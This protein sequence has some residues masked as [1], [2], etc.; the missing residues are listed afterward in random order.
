MIEKGP[1]RGVE[2]NADMYTPEGATG[3]DPACRHGCRRRYQAA[4]TRPRTADPQKTRTHQRRRMTGELYLAAALR[5]GAPVESVRG[6]QALTGKTLAEMRH[7]RRSQDD[8]N[9]LVIEIARAWGR[10]TA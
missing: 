5:N 2:I 9:D 10:S 8:D 7:A 1:R 3:L 6:A 4:F